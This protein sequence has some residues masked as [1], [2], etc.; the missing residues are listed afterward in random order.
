MTDSQ[1]T[2]YKFTAAFPGFLT[3]SQFLLPFCQHHY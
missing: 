3:I 1:K 2:L